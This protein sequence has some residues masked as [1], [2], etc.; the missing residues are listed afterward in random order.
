[1]VSTTKTVSQKY[2]YSL[3]TCKCICNVQL[4]NIAVLIVGWEQA[5]TEVNEGIGTFQL[6]VLFMNLSDEIVLSDG[7]VFSLDLETV[8][9]TAGKMYCILYFP[10]IIMCNS[11]E[12]MG[13]QQFIKSHTRMYQYYS[14]TRIHIRCTSHVCCV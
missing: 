4:P 5:F 13:S 6:R 7:F 10:V 2:N 9:D 1:M 8:P 14:H 3:V 12:C 11:R